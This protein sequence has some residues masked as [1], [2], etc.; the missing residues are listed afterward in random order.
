MNDQSNDPS[1]PLGAAAPIVDL[2]TASINYAP[3]EGLV[4]LANETLG[5]AHVPLGV[6]FAFKGQPFYSVALRVPNGRDF[7]TFLEIPEAQRTPHAWLEIVI[8]APSAILDVMHA[9][10][11]GACIE[12]ASKLVARFAK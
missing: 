5:V 6:P 3:G 7:R 10:D 2:S 9:E 12:A 1:K 4:D 11:Y 8:E